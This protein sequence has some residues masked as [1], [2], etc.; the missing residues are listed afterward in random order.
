MAKRPRGG[1]RRCPL[2]HLRSARSCPCFALPSRPPPSRSSRRSWRASSAASASTRCPPEDHGVDRLASQ[3]PFTIDSGAT[4]SETLFI[5][6]AGGAIGA[7]LTGLTWLVVR[8]ASVPGDLRAHDYAVRVLNEDLEL[9][10][11]DTY[12][13]LERQLRKISNTQGLHVED[14]SHLNARSAA[15]TQTLQRW[16][17]RLHNAERDL[18]AVQGQERWYHRLWRHLPGYENELALT[19]AGRVEPVVAEFR[20]AVETPGGQ[21]AKVRDPTRFTLDDLLNEINRKVPLV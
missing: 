21:S 16:R 4:T 18:V 19:S 8:L 11:A 7:I 6:L 1:H 15:K 10:V 20:R 14:G 13:D 17:D 12:R 5:A 2:C 3:N 9:W